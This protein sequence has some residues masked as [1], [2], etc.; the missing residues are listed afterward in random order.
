MIPHKSLIHAFRHC[1]I[2][3]DIPVTMKPTI[4]GLFVRCLLISETMAFSGLHKHWNLE[5]DDCEPELE[6]SYAGNSHH[7]S[8]P[9]HGHGYGHDFHRGNPGHRNNWD[10]GNPHHG[11]A[12]GHQASSGHDETYRDRGNGDLYTEPWY[13]TADYYDDESTPP[14]YEDVEFTGSYPQ[15]T[16]ESKSASETESASEIVSNSE[17]PESTLTTPTTTTSSSSSST[18]ATTS[19]ASTFTEIL[20]PDVDLQCVQNFFVGCAKKFNA[21]D[22]SQVSVKHIEGV[23]DARICHQRCL[24]DPTCTAWEDSDAQL[25]IYGTCYHHH[26]AVTLDPAQPY[27]RSS[28]GVNSFG[29]RNACQFVTG[30]PTPIPPPDLGPV[31][32]TLVTLPTSASELCPSFDN[33]C[34]NNIRIRCDRD[35][36]ADANRTLSSPGLTCAPQANIATERQCHDACLADKACSGWQGKPAPGA[37]E[38]GGISSCCHVNQGFILLQNP[39]PPPSPDFAGGSYGLYSNCPTTD[40]DALCAEGQCVDGFRVRCRRD[41]REDSMTGLSGAVQ[42]VRG[43]DP[44]VF[45][46]SVLACQ[47]ACAADPSCEAWYGYVTENEPTDGVFVT[48]FVCLVMRNRKITLRPDLSARPPNQLFPTYYGIRGLC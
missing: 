35:L 44:P 29:V 4:L 10:H 8:L 45:V 12:A 2:T 40:D 28:L 18:I 24:A 43:A 22:S 39:L 42:I 5:D 41:V 37:P 9:G 25:S 6:P 27:I 33:R 47:Q 3:S 16:T 38:D 36:L 31:T 34:L 23:T 17:S 20:C 19:S 48:S 46:T 13:D 11:E 7:E 14:G 30:P 32:A 26:E 1:V 21:I 15:P